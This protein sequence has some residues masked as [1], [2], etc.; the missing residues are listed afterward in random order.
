MSETPEGR[1]HLRAARRDT[2]RRLYADPERRA[3]HRAYQREWHRQKRQS[4]PEWREQTN[5]R[6]RMSRYRKHLPALMEAQGGL[7][8]ICGEELPEIGPDVHVDHIYPIAAFRQFGPLGEHLY[9][10]PDNL[11][12]THAH[13]N[14]AKGAAT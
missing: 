1:K 14:R 7:C 2:M 8:G 6:K 4:D 13:C 12:A 11:Q 9:R 3:K 5:E 10:D